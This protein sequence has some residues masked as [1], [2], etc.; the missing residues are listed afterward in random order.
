MSQIYQQCTLAKGDLR[1]TAWVPCRFA[2][3]GKAL[4]VKINGIWEDGWTV[5][6]KFDHKVTEEEL[7][8]LEC[9]FKWTRETSDI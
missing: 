3:K 2:K 8:T 7:E 4:K 9:Q 5:F 1:R 6:L